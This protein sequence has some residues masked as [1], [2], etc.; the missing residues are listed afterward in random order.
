MQVT[1]CACCFSW[2][3]EQL[4]EKYIV[5]R[6]T[7]DMPALLAALNDCNNMQARLTCY[8]SL[9]RCSLFSFAKSLAHANV[10]VLHVLVAWLER[11]LSH[12]PALLDPKNVIPTRILPVFTV[13]SMQSMASVRHSSLN[14]HPH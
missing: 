12:C 8:Y 2:K 7:C 14:V 3:A 9:A 13:W 4:P 11:S 6:H 1:S 10:Y 5:V